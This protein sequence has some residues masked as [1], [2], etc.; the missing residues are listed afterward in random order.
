MR[1][2]RNLL[3]RKLLTLRWSGA[4]GAHFNRKK[5]LHRER[6]HKGGEE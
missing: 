2:R 5:R 1:V 6:K 4:G 3:W